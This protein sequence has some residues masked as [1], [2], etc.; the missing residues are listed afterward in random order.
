MKHGHLHE[1]RRVARETAERSGIREIG[2]E[3][4]T[5]GMALF[6]TARVQRAP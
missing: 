4:R 6:S 1:V 3:S 5:H 2:Q